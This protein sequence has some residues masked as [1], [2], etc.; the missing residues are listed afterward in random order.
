MGS[1]GGK[2]NAVAVVFS[3]V[4]ASGLLVAACS[5]GA[6]QSTAPKPTANPTGK[7]DLDKIFPPGPGRELVF[8]NCF[9]YH[10]LTP[11]VVM[12]S[13]YDRTDWERNCQEHGESLISWLSK[14]QGT[15]CGG[16]LSSTSVQTSRFRN[17][18]RSFWCLGL[19]TLSEGQGVLKDSLAPTL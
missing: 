9:T 3:V 17:S 10:T 12:G 15:S 1:Q 13:R 4:L 14:K 8:E 19:P 2:C 11:I 18:R 16:I 6:K 7:L 5:R